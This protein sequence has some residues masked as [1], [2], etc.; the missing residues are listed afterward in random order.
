VGETTLFD[1]LEQARAIHRL[2]EGARGLLPD[3][4]SP[5]ER[6][7]TATVD[8]AGLEQRIARLENSLSAAHQ[9]L[10]TCVSRGTAT[11]AEDFRTA[12]LGLGLLGFGQ[13]VPAVAVGDDAAIRSVLLRQ[14]AAVLK[15]AGTRRDRY[16]ALRAAPAA[17]EPRARVHQLLERGQAACGQEFVL[18]PS[19]TCDQ[20][21][22]AELA[23]ALA[24]S[25]RQQGGDPL[26]VHGWYVRAARVRDG[27]ARLG[28]CLRLAEVL[29]TGSRMNLTVAQLPFYPDERWVGL[30][31]ADGADLPPSKLSLVIQSTPGVNPAQPL[32]G[33][34]VD[35]WVEVVPS[36]RET[37][38]L[39]F[40]FDPPN[41]FPPQ[42]VLVAVPPVPGQ[43]WT[44]ESL[45]RVL[46]ETLDL[47]K[48][49]AVDPSLLGAAAQYLPALYLPFNAADDAVSTDFTSLTT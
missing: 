23:G 44:T 24:A 34:L 40:Q 48:L 2:L 27:L 1:L 29:A 22:A 38:A 36:R 18:L 13:S 45:R 9:A 4:L 46:M 20:P 7:S 14:A 42:N 16:L 17:A 21:A 33:L 31:P 8:L 41:S 49:R 25:T 39:A 35:E 47:A 19:F 28:T 15:D 43:D 26:A 5:P 11:P 30:P 6:T 12:L 10:A 32:S 37:T 3:D